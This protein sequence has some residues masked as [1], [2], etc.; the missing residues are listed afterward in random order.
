MRARK[1]NVAA[2]KAMWLANEKWRKE[3]GVDE[4]VKWVVLEISSFEVC[5]LANADSHRSFEYH[6]KAEVDRY[7]P[8]FYH[9][10]DKVWIIP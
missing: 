10:V 2:A 4:I 1:F 3:F 5:I 9:K 8:Q 6:E 7:Y